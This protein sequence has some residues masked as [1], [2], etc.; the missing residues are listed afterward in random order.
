M[1]PKKGR[2]MLPT[3]GEDVG[4][5]T[6]KSS[7]IRSFERRRLSLKNLMLEAI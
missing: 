5:A 1:P 7:Q 3:T 6:A 4:L 2:S